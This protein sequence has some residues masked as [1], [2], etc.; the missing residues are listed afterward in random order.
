[1]KTIEF[2]NWINNNWYEPTGTDGNWR[3]NIEHPEF[4]GE[5]PEVNLFTTDELHEKFIN[6]EGTF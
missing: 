1:M 5:L 3:L 2:G 6:K 4:Q